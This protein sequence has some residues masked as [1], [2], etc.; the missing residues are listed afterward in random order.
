MARLMGRRPDPTPRMARAARRHLPHGE[1]V[2]AGVQVQRPG[3]LQAAL[4]GGVSG[5]T[6]TTPGLLPRLTD[7]DRSWVRAAAEFGIDPPLAQRAIYLALVLTPSRLLLLRRSR[8]TRRVREPLAVWPVADVDR[9]EVPRGGGTL[10]IH[11]AGAALRLEL[12]L[13][14]R[15]LPEVYRELPA[16]LAR[17]QAATETP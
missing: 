4:A 11:R 7:D 2:L 1:T 15:F 3:T 17:A 10:T 6:G 13:A 9:I 14:H 8:L 5:A 12:P 16:L